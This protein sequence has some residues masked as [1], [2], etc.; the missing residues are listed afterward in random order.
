MGGQQKPSETAVQEEIA[1]A[2]RDS[3]IYIKR[4]LL[5]EAAAVQE[6]AAVAARNSCTRRT[7]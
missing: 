1:V 5:Q 4:Q 6:K 2:R 7:L 3:C